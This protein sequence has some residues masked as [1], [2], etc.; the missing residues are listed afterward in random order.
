MLIYVSYLCLSLSTSIL[1]GFIG[2]GGGV[3]LRP[4][5]SYFHESA[6]AAAALS[7]ASVFFMALFSFFRYQKNTAINYRVALLVSCTILP[8]TIIGTCAISYIDESYINGAYLLV[9][10]LLLLC[11]LFNK[12]FSNLPSYLVINISLSVLIGFLAGLLGIGGGPFL[13]P[14]LMLAFK[15][16][17]K[18]ITGTSVFIVLLSSTVSLGQHMLAMNLDYMKAL[19]LIIG[20]IFGG[21]WELG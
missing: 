2:I 1:G 19:P 8:G 20:A 7:I 10:I 14:L 18:Q 5:L 6:N 17:S 9:L 3:I 12:Q 21:H 13:I 11:T 16:N 4:S 15:L